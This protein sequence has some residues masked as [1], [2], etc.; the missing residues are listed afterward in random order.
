MTALIL[1]TLG[2]ALFHTGE[3]NWSG[4]AQLEALDLF[5]SLGN[6]WGIAI[7]L[8][9]LAQLA[10]LRGD[11]VA[12]ARLFGA[13]EE[14]RRRAAIGAWPTVAGDH[15]AGVDAVASTLGRAEYERAFAEGRSWTRDEAVVYAQ[16]AVLEPLLET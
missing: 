13:E 12:A 14:L 15:H 4:T 8:D 1:A 11:A 7:C 16:N 10:A 2:H 9:G 6:P 3:I 5:A